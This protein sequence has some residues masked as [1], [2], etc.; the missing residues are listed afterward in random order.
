[1]HAH[2]FARVI[3]RAR[4]MG[5]SGCDDQPRRAVVFMLE[6]VGVENLLIRVLHPRDVPVAPVRAYLFDFAHRPADLVEHMGHECVGHG[7]GGASITLRCNLS[8]LHVQGK[9]NRPRH[10][11]RTT[12]RVS[13]PCSHASSALTGR[14][15]K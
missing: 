6:A 2:V 13:A 9:K 4:A 14:G 1:M 12:P 5:S 3:T 10:T 15:Q 8:Y 11:E 7:Q